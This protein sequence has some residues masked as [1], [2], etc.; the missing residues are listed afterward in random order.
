MHERHQSDECVYPQATVAL[1]DN[2]MGNE[3]MDRQVADGR[4][5]EPASDKIIV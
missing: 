4:K 1:T 2:G 5:R 3:I